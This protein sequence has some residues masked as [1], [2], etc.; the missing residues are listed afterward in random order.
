MT[1]NKIMKTMADLL[2]KEAQ[3]F[4][5]YVY[6]NTP[7]SCGLPEALGTFEE[8]L[9]PSDDNIKIERTEK[10]TRITL[11]PKKGSGKRKPYVVKIWIS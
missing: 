2:K 5:N 9:I 10:E 4:N 1:R 6:C 8:Y 3:R 7:Y 11:N